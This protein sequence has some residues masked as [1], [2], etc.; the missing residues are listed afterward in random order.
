MDRAVISDYFMEQLVN[1]MHAPLSVIDGSG[2][3][4]KSYGLNDKDK[5]VCEYEAELIA[6]LK[7]LLKTTSP[8]MTDEEGKCYAALSLQENGMIVVGPI[9]FGL[10]TFNEFA[11]TLLLL[12]HQITGQELR[13]AKFLK[14][15]QRFYKSTTGYKELV[16]RD[17]FEKN[18]NAFVHNPY[19]QELRE[20]SSIERGDRKGLAESISETYEGKVGTLAD[21]PL[22][23]HKNVAIGNITLASRAAIRGG[24]SAEKS[25]S[26]ADTL[27]Q[28]V[29]K[30]DNI[31]EVEA[32]KREAQFAFIGLVEE[33]KGHAGNIKSRISPLVQKTKDYIFSHLNESIEIAEIAEELGVNADYLSHLFSVEEKITISGYIRHEK[34]LRSE[35]L[36]KYSNYKVKEIAYYLGFCSQSHFSR[37]FKEKMGISPDEYRRRFGNRLKWNTKK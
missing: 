17:F 28:R 3:L 31:V 34:L 36:L 10:V 1:I 18:E 35:N 37:A 33:E 19:D 2:V 12:N 22:R 29:E 25:F 9:S 26:L 11:S 15:N 21:D 5:T 20:I 32:F 8:C 27:I 24:V 13:L 30:I 7:D 16:T 14:N 6:H 23:S 4:R